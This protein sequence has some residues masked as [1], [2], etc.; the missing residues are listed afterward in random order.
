MQ[1]RGVSSVRSPVRNL[2]DF[3][4]DLDHETFVSSVI[5]SFAARFGVE[6]KYAVV[7]EAMMLENNYIASGME[8]L[9]VRLPPIGE[10][11]EE[12]L[13]T[14]NRRGNGSTVRLLISGIL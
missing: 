13:T 11:F 1:G 9:L 12:K 7:D 10:T 6:E 5:N 8:E 3:R 4:P 2:Q 14:R